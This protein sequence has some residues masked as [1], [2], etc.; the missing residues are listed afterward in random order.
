MCNVTLLQLCKTATARL[1]VQLDKSRGQ[2]HS[3]VQTPTTRR[4]RRQ[5]S[6]TRVKSTLT[7]KVQS[8][9]EKTVPP[10]FK[11]LSKSADPLIEAPYP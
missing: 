9:I 11:L 2:R 10:G 7:E 3:F 5:E 4:F 1:S 8:S 6:S